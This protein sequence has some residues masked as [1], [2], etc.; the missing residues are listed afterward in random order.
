[1]IMIAQKPQLPGS[2]T[3]VGDAGGPF[4]ARNSVD[5]ILVTREYFNGISGGTHFRES[6]RIGRLRAP[7][8]RPGLITCDPPTKLRAENMG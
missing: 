1:M 5:E 7:P 8:W 2:K 3:L 4:A 6:C